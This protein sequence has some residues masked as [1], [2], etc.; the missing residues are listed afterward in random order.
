M[1][2]PGNGIT[3]TSEHPHELERT[4]RG[5]FIATCGC[6]WRGQ[7]RPGRKGREDALRDHRRHLTAIARELL[8][9]RGMI[10]P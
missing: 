1:T 7:A 4:P 6:G 3:W 5:S 10:A 8:I 2:A 9:E